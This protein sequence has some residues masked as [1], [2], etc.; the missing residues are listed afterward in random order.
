VDS[1]SDENPFVAMRK[2]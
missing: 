1:I 2:K